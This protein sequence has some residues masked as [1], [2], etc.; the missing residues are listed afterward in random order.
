M[1]PPAVPLLPLLI[2]AIQ[3]GAIFGLAAFGLR[4]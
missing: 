1:L 3:A 2:V 4:P